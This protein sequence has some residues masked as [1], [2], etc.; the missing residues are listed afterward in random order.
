MKIVGVG[1]GPGMLTQE[2]IAV[3]GEAVRIYG[4]GRAIGM[5]KC[6]I[7][8]D[9]PVIEIAD[10]GKIRELEHDAVIL[11]TGDPMLAGLGF[12]GAE[13][14]PGISSMQLAFARLGLSLANASVVVAHGGGHENAMKDV[15]EELKRGRTVFMIVDPGFSV[16]DLGRYVSSSG[17]QC[18]IAVCEDLGYPSERIAIATT[19]APPET[20]SR[21]FSVVL[22]KLGERSGSD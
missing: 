8:D 3:I 9:C 1:C 22:G 16:R 18:D 6:H 4:S 20:R 10:Y 2:A 12:A 5:V 21:L 7:R 14:I 11:S 15:A 19:S 17:L 13:V